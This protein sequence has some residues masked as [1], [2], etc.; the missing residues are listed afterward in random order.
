M[1]LSQNTGSGVWSASLNSDTRVCLYLRSRNVAPVLSGK[2]NCRYR[3]LRFITLVLK[4]NYISYLCIQKFS[5][6][7]FRDS[8]SVI[9]LKCEILL[10]C[11]HC[12]ERLK[13]K[14]R[15]HS[16]V[17]LLEII[18]RNFVGNDIFAASAVCFRRTNTK[19][20]E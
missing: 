12:A 13:V 4:I 11:P 8:T 1:L 17:S 6:Q 9:I 2:L 14:R 19:M 16:L 3:E 18:R 5:I 7:L 10:I 20:A 15:G